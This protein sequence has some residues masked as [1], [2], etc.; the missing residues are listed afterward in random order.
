[1]ACSLAL[2]VS[3]QALAIDYYS[4]ANIGD[5]DLTN[6]SNWSTAAC[7]GAQAFGSFSM[8][9]TYTIQICSG[10]SL[11][12]NTATV[13]AGKLV[14]GTWGGATAGTWGGGG[15]LKFDSGSTHNKSIENRNHPSIL[16]SVSIA[17]DIS[18]MAIGDI[19]ANMGGSTANGDIRFS[20]VVT[21]G[22]K[23]LEC[24]VGTPY[25]VNSP[26][27]TCTVVAA[28]TIVNAPID[29]HFSKQVESYSTEIELK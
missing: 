18:N 20:S 27:G 1:M 11:T 24:P 16:P 10:Y 14:F 22:G 23:K 5:G 4:K 17:L 26:A 6:G 7:G 3:G 9:D 13:S 29:L 21:G 25:T 15:V 12:L 2:L 28:S 19:I 8:D